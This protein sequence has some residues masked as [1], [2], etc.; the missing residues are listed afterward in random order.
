[1]SFIM[2]WRRVNHPDY[3]PSTDDWW[4]VC[5]WVKFY[6]EQLVEFESGDML[7]DILDEVDLRMF[8]T[9]LA[10]GESGLEDII[11]PW[12]E[13][14]GAN[15]RNTTGWVNAMYVLNQRREREQK[16][17]LTVRPRVDFANARLIKR[18][19]KEPADVHRISPY[20]FEELIAELLE[21]MGFAVTLTPTDDE[22]GPGD[23]GRDILAWNEDE[24]GKYLLI[25]DTKL[26][27]QSRRVGVSQVRGLLGAVVD[28]TVRR[29]K[30]NTTVRGLLVTSSHFSARARDFQRRHEYRLT[31]RDFEGVKEWI[32]RHTFNP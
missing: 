10:L 9:Y 24:Q 15:H 30:E 11:Q 13:D 28:E 6:P 22:R 21:G 16:R 2:L 14:L 29:T 23:Q 25:V 5:D 20:R 12:D 26:Y 7:L 18:L 4:G 1:M 8:E 19:K 32:Q 31:L 27:G 3:H 17:K